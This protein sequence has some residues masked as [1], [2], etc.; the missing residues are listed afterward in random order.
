M[1][2]IVLEKGILDL[3]GDDNIQMQWIAFRFQDKLRDQ[4]T[5]NFTIPKTENNIKILDVYSLLD[6]EDV[7]F[8]AKI[9]P[10]SLQFGDKIYDIYVQIVSVNDKDIEICVFEDGFHDL[11]KDAYLNDF[12]KDNQNTI[13]EW[14]NMSMT[15]YPNDFKKYNYGAPYSWLFAQRHPSKRLNDIL[16]MLGL[17]LNCS[18]Q[19]VDPTWRLLANKKYVCPENTLQVLEITDFGTEMENN[20]FTIKGGQHVTN[21]VSLGG[22]QTM[23]FNRDVSTSMR[24]WWAYEKKG[25]TTQPKT[26][27]L[28]V[29]DVTKKIVLN[30]SS[31]NQVLYGQGY[32]DF[33]YNFKKDDVM[34]LYCD[35]TDKLR[36]CSMVIRMTHSSYQITD[37]DYNISLEYKDRR[38]R[39][40][41]DKRVYV[42]IPNYVYINMDGGNHD[43]LQTERLSF[44]YF[45]YWAN[46]PKIKL[47]EF[48]HSLQWLVGGKLRNNGGSIYFDSNL[49]S[50][51]WDGQLNNIEIS[52]DRV[53]QNNYVKYSDDEYASPITTINNAWLEKDKDFH[54]SIFKYLPDNVV[55]QYTLEIDK[56]AE[57][58]E[59]IKYTFNDFDEP[60]LFAYDG[61]ST[62]IPLVYF[63]MDKINQ[64]K[65]IDVTLYN[66]REDM[67]NVDTLIFDGRTYYVIEG[68]KD[69]N[70]NIV[71]LK[72][73]LI[74]NK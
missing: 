12:F 38:P 47:G 40:T 73:L 14:N 59:H 35:D 18:I 70:K 1:I 9:K 44:A 61:N 3:Y 64:S 32:T 57:W 11:I 19:S 66:P 43:G 15:T 36:S 7:Q 72:L 41:V 34:T 23:I 20:L 50:Y 65:E 27:Y 13:Y 48:F 56:D 25:T 30:T 22:S 54:K 68:T 60:V 26:V 31:G 67:S 55:P 74:F 69:M 4:Y 17:H 24:I 16:P 28:K 53:G 52:S 29:N 63:D 37:D 5:N 8:G 6:T 33:T 21:D 39:L 10:G 49:K 42:G 62:Q 58:D 51:Q 2:N 46:A 45:G 71:N